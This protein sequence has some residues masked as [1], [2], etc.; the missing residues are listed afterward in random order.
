MA[1]TEE[2]RK[3]H[4]EYLEEER[5]KYRLRAYHDEAQNLIYAIAL[6][7]KCIAFYIAAR[8]IEVLWAALLRHAIFK[9][10]IPH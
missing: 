7:L 8:G 2:E 3:A 10:G 5:Q 9:E 4:R 1:M 6:L